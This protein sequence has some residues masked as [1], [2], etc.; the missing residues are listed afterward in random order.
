MAP[1]TGHLR[2]GELSRR[3]GVSNQLLRAWERRYGLLEPMRTEGGYRLYSD[4][5]ERRVAAMLA[6]LERG[7]SAAEAARL[8][9][10]TAES[11]DAPDATVLERGTQ[12][13]RATLDS[14]DEAGAHAA[15]DRLLAELS[16]EAVLREAV[17]PYLRELGERWASG[18][19][20]IGQEHFATG[21]LRG[22]LLGLARGWGRGTGP[23]ALLA[24]APDEH[25]ELGLITFGLGLRDLT[26]GS[27]TSVPTP[28]SRL[29]EIAESLRPDAVVIATTTA[30]AWRT[31]GRRSPGSGATSRSGSQ[32]RAPIA[33]SRKRRRRCSTSIRSRP[34]SVWRPRSR[35]P[36]R[37]ARR[38]GQRDGPGDDDVLRESLDGDR[39]HDVERLVSPGSAS[40]RAA[41]ERLPRSRAGS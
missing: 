37:G 10:D 30:D 8:A 9:L 20:S 12:Q 6:N 33:S 19:A 31:S 28:R 15:L 5:D 3:S 16:V 1:E 27:P 39:R 32:A 36:G 23:H 11:V 18:D 41:R 25:H 26:G 35:F 38:S 17:L 7:L 4:Q 29:A 14:L 2:I 21:I 22:R 24:C 34:R 13:L 40:T